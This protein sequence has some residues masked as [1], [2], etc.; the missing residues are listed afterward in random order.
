MDSA[1]KAGANPSSTL[2]LGWSTSRVWIVGSDSTLVRADSLVD[3]GEPVHRYSLVTPR[4][5]TT[6]PI[7][8]N[9]VLSVVE[10]GAMLG[11]H[12]FDGQF[13]VARMAWQELLR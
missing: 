10:G 12:T 4:S 5:I 2:Q 11:N 6:G 13:R 1:A 9:R 8:S 3:A 7:T